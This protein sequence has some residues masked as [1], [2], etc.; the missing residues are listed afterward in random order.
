MVKESLFEKFPVEAIYGMHNWPGMPVG[1]FAVASGPMMVAFDIFDLVIRGQG[2]HGAM[3]HQ[4]IDS[5][6]VASQVVSALQSITSRNTDP[7]NSLVVSVPQI[8]G[9]DAYNV[10]PDEIILRGTV[11]SFREEV[12]DGVEPAMKR[13]ADGVCAAYGTSAE[14]RYP[15]TVNSVEE[16]E[17]AAE[18]TKEIVSL[19]VINRS[20]VPSMGS[21]DFAYMLRE[22]PLLC[23]DRQWRGRRGLHAPQPWL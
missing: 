13:I 8:H 20:S 12:R 9:G 5:I 4:G 6:V 10:I 23:V 21:E 19:D 22:K 3:P 16:T 7:I 14:L 11:R 1:E 17:L 2:S 18:A 15:A